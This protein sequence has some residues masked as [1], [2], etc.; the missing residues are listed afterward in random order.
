MHEKGSVK[1]EVAVAR[2]R[3]A[4]IRIPAERRSIF[5]LIHSFPQQA[6]IHYRK[7]NGTE[8]VNPVAALFGPMKPNIPCS[9]VL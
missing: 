4:V 2:G 6:V 8:T 9:V 3:G 5:Y 1:V 7:A